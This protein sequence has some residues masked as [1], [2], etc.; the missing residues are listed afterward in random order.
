[1]PLDAPVIITVRSRNQAPG[2]KREDGGR[3]ADAERAGAR[4]ADERR[5]GA[6][7]V[8]RRAGILFAPRVAAG[9]WTRLANWSGNVSVS[10]SSKDFGGLPLSMAGVMNQFR[11]RLCVSIDCVLSIQ[12]GFGFGQAL[13]TL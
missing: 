1:M 8:G 5:G 2:P 7:R 4:A 6:W 13:F 10:I 11:V 12:L 9:L 3:A